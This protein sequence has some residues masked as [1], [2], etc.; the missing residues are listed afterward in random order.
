MKTV[1]INHVSEYVKILVED[2]QQERFYHGTAHLQKLYRGQSKIGF[3]LLPA[4]FRTNDDFL[5]ERLYLQEFQRELPT[6]TSGLTQFDILVKAQ[7]YGIPTRLL[8]FTLNPLVALY[9]ACSSDFDCDG[10]VF[11]CGPVGLFAQDDLLFQVIMNYLFKFKQGQHWSSSLT[12]FLA[13]TIAHEGNNQYDP[14]SGWALGIVNSSLEKDVFPLYILPALT[15]PRIR[16]QQGAFALFHTPLHLA[17]NKADTSYFELPSKDNHAIT[18]IG[19]TLRINHNKK[20]QIL[21]ELD[22]IGINEST[23]FPEL[24]N[25]AKDIVRRIRQSNI[26]L[27]LR[28]IR[29]NP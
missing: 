15:N 19:Q 12:S 27:N 25:H 1:E 6:E 18:K 7:H 23:L 2:D 28:T 21:S 17:K 20:A 8:D 29:K 11:E 10:E 16:A 4:S 26:A 24:E 22:R 9:F 14:N 5:N 3:P 13:S